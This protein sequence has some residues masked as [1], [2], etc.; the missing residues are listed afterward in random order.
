MSTGDYSPRSSHDSDGSLRA[1]ELTEGPSGYAAGL[2]TR[3]SRSYSVSG[4]QF[5]PDLFQLTATLED[6]DIMKRGD[7]GEKRIGFMKGVA[8]CVGLQ[9]GP[10]R[11]SSV[12]SYSHIKS[13]DWIRY[14][15]CFFIPPHIRLAH[16]L[17]LPSSSPGIV[18]ENTQS[19]GASMVVWIASGILGWTGAS[20]FAELGASIPVSGGA[21]AYL[22][23]AYG[24][25]MSY[26]FTWTSIALKPG[27]NAVIGLIFGVPT[28]ATKALS[29]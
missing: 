3:Q 24:P 7:L 14:I 17:E 8:L 15:V 12:H 10:Y 1:L 25:L 13:L 9:V 18:V 5:E 26:L 19:V 22:A 21:Q 23:Y 16:S 27:S 28:F 4:F 11:L 2:S 20:S 29:R 6:S